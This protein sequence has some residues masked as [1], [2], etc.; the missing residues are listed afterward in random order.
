MYCYLMNEKREEVWS[1][2]NRVKQFAASRTSYQILVKG[3]PWYVT[4]RKE[5]RE[6]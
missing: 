1:T 3:C 5:A 6:L 2:A 4:E